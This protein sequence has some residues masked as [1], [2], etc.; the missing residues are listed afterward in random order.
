MN[1]ESDIPPKISS[2]SL[3][4]VSRWC[5]DRAKQTEDRKLLKVLWARY[6]KGSMKTPFER[7]AMALQAEVDEKT[8]FWLH[9]ANTF[10][11]EAANKDA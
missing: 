6:H 5:E 2:W 7:F 3:N 9:M 8:E 1:T 11:E 4:L 10:R